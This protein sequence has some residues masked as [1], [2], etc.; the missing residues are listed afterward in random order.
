MD[1]PA[2]TKLWKTNKYQ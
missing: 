1:Q 2:T